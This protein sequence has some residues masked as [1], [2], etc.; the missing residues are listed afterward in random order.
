MAETG[1]QILGLQVLNLP[2]F[3][4]C[5]L[6]FSVHRTHTAIHNDFYRD[7]PSFTLNVCLTQYSNRAL[8]QQ[9]SQFTSKEFRQLCKTTT[10]CTPPAAHCFLKETAWLNVPL[11]QSNTS[12]S[13]QQ[14]PVRS[15][16]SV[17]KTPLENG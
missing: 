16:T 3:T 14:T 1:S 17:S 13:R 5:G 15:I 6:L 11:R 2:T 4:C 12:S 8:D 9:R 7:Y 10:L